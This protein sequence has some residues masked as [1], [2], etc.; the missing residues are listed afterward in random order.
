MCQYAYY[1]DKEK[2]ARLRCNLTKDICLYS[3]YCDRQH[4]YIHREGVENCYMAMNEQKKNIPSNA[5][6]VRFVKKG[7]AYVEM[8][9]KIV[10]IKDT[11]GNIGNYVYVFDNG[12]GEYE[13][14][15][16]PIEPK[17]KKKSTRKKS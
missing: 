16:S 11:L 7:Y 13:I 17:E 1:D 15:L 9:D 12:N 8:G 2:N 14:S 4:K 3:K 6:F 5:H 10:K